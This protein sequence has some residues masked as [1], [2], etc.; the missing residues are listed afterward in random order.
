MR[1][2]IVATDRADDFQAWVSP[3]LVAMSRLASRLTSAADAD[4]VVQ[5]SLVRAWRK[6]ST[7]D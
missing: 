1:A 2:P 7:Y 3:H 5:E 4:D 6:R